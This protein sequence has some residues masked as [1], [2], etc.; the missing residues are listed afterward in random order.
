[1]ETLLRYANQYRHMNK[2]FINSDRRNGDG[3]E[4]DRTKR[5]KTN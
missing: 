2:N 5:E 4:T 1:M 3:Y